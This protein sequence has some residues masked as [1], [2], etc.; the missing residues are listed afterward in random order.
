M[1]A[2]LFAIIALFAMGGTGTAAD[3][4]DKRIYKSPHPVG[5]GFICA[6]GPNCFLGSSSRTATGW[7]GGGGFEYALWSNVS[8]KAEY[9]YVNLGNGDA[10]N[11]VAVSSNGQPIPSL[12]TANYSGSNLNFHV[13]RA[14]INFR[15]AS[16]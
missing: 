15:F 5:F 4:P 14:G 6:A 12:F 1:K 2:L 9:Q 7:T 13:V 3:L 10:F 16:F 8:A 11:V